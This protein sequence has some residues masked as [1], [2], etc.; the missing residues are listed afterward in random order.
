MRI[1]VLILLYI[2]R[3]GCRCVLILLIYSS[4]RLGSRC[5]LILLIYIQQYE[6]RVSMCPHTADIN[7]AV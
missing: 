3:C 2:E 4:M 7:T 1:C 5:V 6:F